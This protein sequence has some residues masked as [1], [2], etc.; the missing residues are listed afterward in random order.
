MKKTLLTL[1][2][3]TS[4][5]YALNLNDTSYYYDKGEIYSGS[6]F[7]QSATKA[8]HNSESYTHLK[9]G[10]SEMQNVLGLVEIGDASIETAAKNGNIK[11]I[12]HVDTEV[13]KVYIPLLFLPIYAKETK[14][15]V[16][17]E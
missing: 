12:H 2:L 1:F 6:T 4:I 15:I 13:S 8:I 9:R 16:Y 3:L 14:T 17:G 10:T 11:K 5:T 7:P